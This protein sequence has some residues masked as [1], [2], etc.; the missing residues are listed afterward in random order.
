VYAIAQL[1]IYYDQR[2]RKEGFDIEWM[3]R[4]AGMVAAAAAPPEGAP[5]MAAIPR[6]ADAAPRPAD[7]VASDAE[8]PVVPSTAVDAAEH[9]TSVGDP[10]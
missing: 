9:S 1:L 6:R 4:Q 7:G 3:M 2:I 10:A 8:T 5:W